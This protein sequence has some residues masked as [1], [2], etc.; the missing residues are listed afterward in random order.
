MPV[1][2]YKCV[3]CEHVKEVTKSINDA[4]VVELC[5][6][7]GS[8]MIKQYGSFGIQFKGSGF[9]KTDNAK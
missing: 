1:Y 2:E 7:C 9:Y 6:N 3:L 8:A 5:S 4:S